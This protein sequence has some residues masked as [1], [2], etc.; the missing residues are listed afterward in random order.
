MAAIATADLALGDRRNM[1]YAGTVATY[2][3]GRAVVVATGMD[4]EFGKIAKDNAVEMA[5]PSDVGAK[6]K[7]AEIAEKVTKTTNTEKPKRRRES[8]EARVIRELHRHGIY[9]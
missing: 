3:R 1:G 8:T 5:K 7:G 9:W 2:G 4:T 6:N